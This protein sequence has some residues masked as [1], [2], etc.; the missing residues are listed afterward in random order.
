MPLPLEAPKPP[1]AAPEPSLRDAMAAPHGR[2][3]KRATRKRRRGRAL[4]GPTGPG[5]NAER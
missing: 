1:P 5:G 4:R 3:G 2:K